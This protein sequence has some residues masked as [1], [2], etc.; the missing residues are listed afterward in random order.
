M[1][2]VLRTRTIAPGKVTDAVAWAHEMA[3][4]FEKKFGCPN[5]VSMP[6]GGHPHRIRWTVEVAGFAELGEMLKKMQGDAHYAQMV[7]QASELFMAGAVDDEI[8]QA[9]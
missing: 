6:V 5:R 9:V 2:T 8:W 1:I 4:Y 3:A 7:A